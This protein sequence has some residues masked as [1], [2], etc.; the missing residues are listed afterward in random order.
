MIR[1]VNQK[2]VI[3]SL[4]RHRDITE[5]FLTQIKTIPK[6][7][8]E[9]LGTDQAKKA[10]A[11]SREVNGELHSFKAFLRLSVSPHGILYAKIEKMN[12]RNEKPLLQFFQNRFPQFIFLLETD[13]GVF[14][15]HHNALFI[16][17]T[18]S[19]EEIVKE[20]EEKLPR[21]SILEDLNGK[22]YQELWESF[23][24]SQLIP[25]R[26][27]SKQVLNLAKKWNQV[28]AVDKTRVKPL[29]EFF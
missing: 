9:N 10:V 16:L 12:H 23:A 28:V 6:D 26:E 3:D 27:T 29:E 24:Q 21:S 14:T 17:P 1:R 11:M 13:K 20:F 2:E 4:S 25:E 7:I 5:E 22:N 15:I 8:L 18:K 19:L